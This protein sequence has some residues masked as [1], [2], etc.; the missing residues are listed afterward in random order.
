MKLGE[1]VKSIWLPHVQTA[2]A[3]AGSEN[4]FV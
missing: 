2:H 3:T 1:T 4:P